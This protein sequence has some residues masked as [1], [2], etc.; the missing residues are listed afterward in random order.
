[1]NCNWCTY[2]ILLGILLWYLLN[3]FELNC[4]NEFYIPHIKNLL[5]LENLLI[6]NFINWNYSNFYFIVSC[7]S[8]YICMSRRRNII[9][10]FF[11]DKQTLVV[12]YDDGFIVIFYRL[13]I[14]ALIV[15]IFLKIL[16]EMFLGN[17]FHSLK[18][19]NKKCRHISAIFWRNTILRS[20]VWRWTYF[21]YP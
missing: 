17:W 19:W 13:L 8:R 9:E 6:V 1:M 5:V 4:F 2:K 18:S 14:L 3:F 12:C 20:N 11:A 16:N 7:P 10:T 21:W 15:W